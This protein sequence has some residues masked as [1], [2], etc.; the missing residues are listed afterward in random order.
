MNNSNV[1]TPSQRISWADMAQEDDE[2][3]DEEDSNNGGNFAV[4]DSN[5]FSHVAKVVAEKPTLPREQREYIR[6]MNVRRK[7]DFICFERVHGKL[8]NILEGLELHTGIFS[9]AEQKRIVN[10]VASLQEMGKKG[11]LKGLLSQ[12]NIY[13]VVI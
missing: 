1:E 13:F 8:V 10:Y 12:L 6:F 3:G 4:G 11:E 5:A 7:K 9:A 2:F